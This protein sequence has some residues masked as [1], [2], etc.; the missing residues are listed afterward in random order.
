MNLIVKITPYKGVF[1]HN[2]DL[3]IP[4][5]YEINLAKDAPLEF[6][7]NIALDL[8]AYK[9]PIKELDCFKIQVFDN[10]VEIVEK[11]DPELQRYHQFGTII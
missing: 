6:K 1:L 8:I 2:E 7:A 5:E 10:E 4:G 9:I 3:E 11:D